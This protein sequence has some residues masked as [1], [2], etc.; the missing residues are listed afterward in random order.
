MKMI[1]A[2]VDS[3]INSTWDKCDRCCGRL[4]TLCVCVCVCVCVRAKLIS[5]KVSSSG[6]RT[7]DRWHQIPGAQPLGHRSSLYTDG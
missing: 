1:P 4:M 5:G 3:N 6:I 7:C 2:L